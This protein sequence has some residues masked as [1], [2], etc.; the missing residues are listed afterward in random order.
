MITTRIFINDFK[1][2]KLKTIDWDNKFFSLLSLLY[3]NIW[4][5]N[6]LIKNGC[7]EKISEYRQAIGKINAYNLYQGFILVVSPQIKKMYYHK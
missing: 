4:Q 5:Y 6:I 7:N 3:I 2:L 1:Y